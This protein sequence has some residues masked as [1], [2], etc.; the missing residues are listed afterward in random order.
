MVLFKLRM[1]LVFGPNLVAVA[2]YPLKG[3][4]TL[5]VFVRECHAIP[6]RLPV[7][8]LVYR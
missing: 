6:V 3:W 2:L 7:R 5:F 1:W 4:H 8:A